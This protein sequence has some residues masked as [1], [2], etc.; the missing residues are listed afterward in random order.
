LG[1]EAFVMPD[2]TIQVCD[3]DNATGI[4]S[5]PVFL[6][7]YTSIAAAYG[8]EFSPDNTKLYVTEFNGANIF[9]F[10]LSAAN[11]SSTML[12]I[13]T[14]IGVKSSLTLGPNGKIYAAKQS[15]AE[16]GAIDFPNVAGMGCVYT[17]AAVLLT[18]GINSIGS[19]NVFRTCA[20]TTSMMTINDSQNIFDVFPNPASSMLT[21][22]SSEQIKQV[23]ISDVTGRV[24]FETEAGAAGKKLNVRINVSNFSSGIYF[25]RMN[26]GEKVHLKKLMVE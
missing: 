15:S 8:C 22:R 25:L 7:D 4:V 20:S 19:C 13:A 12:N 16:I 2:T 1:G 23:K 26:A 21:V 9:Q 11:P 17:D 5:N 14:T 3:F 24:V 6:A 18:T 10:D